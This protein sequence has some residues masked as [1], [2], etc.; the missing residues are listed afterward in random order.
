MSDYLNYTPSW[1]IDLN[2]PWVNNIRLIWNRED[3]W[4]IIY[5]FDWN[6]GTPGNLFDID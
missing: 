4:E 2:D 1:N 5:E 3:S 6:D